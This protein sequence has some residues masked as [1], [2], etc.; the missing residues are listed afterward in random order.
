MKREYFSGLYERERPKSTT[1]K[2]QT[3]PV[4]G[5]QNSYSIQRT[6]ST[7]VYGTQRVAP[8]Q[9]AGK[10]TGV[11]KTRIDGI[12]GGDDNLLRERAATG[13]VCPVDRTNFDSSFSR[14]S[15]NTA[16]EIFQGT[17]RKNSGQHNIVE[18]YETMKLQEQLGG[19]KKLHGIDEIS[20]TTPHKCATGESTFADDI[21]SMVARA[22]IKFRRTA[23]SLSIAAGKSIYGCAS[24]AA[25]QVKDL[26]Q[27]NEEQCDYADEN[28][29]PLCVDTTFKLDQRPPP[30]NG[31]FDDG[32]QEGE[33]SNILRAFE[34]TRPA[35]ANL[36]V[37]MEKRTGLGSVEP[38]TRA[39]NDCQKNQ[40][41]QID[42]SM[43]LVDEQWKKLMEEIM[44]HGVS[45]SWLSAGDVTPRTSNTSKRTWEPNKEKVKK[46][47]LDSLNCNKNNAFAEEDDIEFSL[48]LLN[49]NKDTVVPTR[50]EVDFQLAS[51]NC[52]TPLDCAKPDDF[53]KHVIT[54]PR[55]GP[56]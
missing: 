1:Q 8:A 24:H 18:E 10:P 7:P 34:V 16:S 39:T 38:F 20:A 4:W 23:R 51:L 29:P 17:E 35:S 32:R 19:S 43:E 42:D 44:R 6:Q 47:Q 55:L 41:L 27:T 3:I 26:G 56:K 12:K 46:F 53:Q 45:R 2:S 13:S 50:V 52:M 54:L 33:A 49:C 25:N 30:L 31:K 36:R 5:H 28:A 21:E 48:E 15:S 40:C 11:R 22:G 9:R 37:P 14:D